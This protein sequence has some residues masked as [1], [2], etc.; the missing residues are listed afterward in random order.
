[1]Q[2][3]LLKFSETIRNSL[4]RFTLPV[5][6]KGPLRRELLTLDEMA[7]YAEQL[8]ERHRVRTIY[9]RGRDL[10]KVFRQSRRVIKRGY[11]ELSEAVHKQGSVIPGAE[12][13]LDNYH[14]IEQNG[15][16]V[17][18]DL[19]TTYYRKLPKLKRGDH[20][21]YPRVLHLAIEFLTHSDSK[22][23]AATLAS[24]VTGYQRRKTLTL[25][26]L[27]AIPIMLRLVLIENLRRIV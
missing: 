23:E 20:R 13:L 14:I 25:G 27:W 8:A 11:F 1:M 21:G 2:S 18:Q 16:E 26:E 10:L 22:V 24:F 9:D 12:W 6:G 15:R 4:T 7:V 3:R 19:P 5:L 17:L